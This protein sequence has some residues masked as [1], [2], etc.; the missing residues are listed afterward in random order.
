M[1]TPNR[2]RSALGLLARPA[3]A[4]VNAISLAGGATVET[5]TLPT[6][7]ALY[8]VIFGYS[9]GG[10]YVRAGTVAAAWTPADTTDGT[11]F[12]LAPAALEVAGGTV[13]SFQC[14]AAAIVTMDVYA[15]STAAG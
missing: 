5:L 2:L 3:P 14:A 7:V 8:I 12:S 6:T 9:A 13:I 10:V 1:A 4:Y 11:A 15:A